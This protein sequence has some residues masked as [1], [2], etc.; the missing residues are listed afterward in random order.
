[1]S[2]SWDSRACMPAAK[3]VS[4]S[5]R[6]ARLVS[7]AGGAGAAFNISRTSDQSAARKAT[8]NRG[9]MRAMESRDD[10]M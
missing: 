8:G 5:E 6:K 1:M 10:C 7:G 4:D 3:S 9:S 2:T